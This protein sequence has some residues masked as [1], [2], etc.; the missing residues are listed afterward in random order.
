MFDFILPVYKTTKR[1]RKGFRDMQE[2]MNRHTKEQ[3]QQ[4]SSSGK[5]QNNKGSVGEYI[6]FE[7]VK[8]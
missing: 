6:D 4:Q 5:N 1:M 7:E 8:D 2:Q 3:F